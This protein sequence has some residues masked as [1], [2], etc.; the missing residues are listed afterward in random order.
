MTSQPCLSKSRCL[1]F[2][3]WN[4]PGVTPGMRGKKFSMGPSVFSRVRYPGWFLCHRG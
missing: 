1:R 4:A 3:M 2:H